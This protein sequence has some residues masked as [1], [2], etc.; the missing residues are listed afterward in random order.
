VSRDV[1]GGRY[2]LLEVLG[3]EGTTEVVRAVDLEH[4]RA[5]ALKVRRLTPDVSREGLLAEGRTLLGARPHPSLPTVRDG[6]FLDDDSYVLVMDWVEGIGLER[7]VEER[8]DPGLP[9]GAVLLGLEAAAAALD[10]LHAHTPPI[11]HGDVQ[12]KNILV[13]PDAHLTLVFGVG[14]TG[15]ALSETQSPYR[16]PEL[17]HSAPTRST[18]VYGL[19]ATA[20]F[21]L[22]GSPPP[23]D[24]PV[25]WVG[26]PPDL[27]KRIDRVI[28]RALDPDPARRPAGAAGFVERL[29]ATRETEVPAG[30]VT[31]VLTDVEGSTDLWEAHPA[32]MAKVM[33][34]HYELA[35][36][37]A[38]A[39]GG[40]MP[41][42]QGEGDSTL[43]AYARATDALDAIL[44]F[45]RAI[46]AEPWPD[47]IDLRVRAG[48][49]TGEAQVEYG[50]Y[51]GATLNRAAR[52]RALARGGEVLLSQ[53]TAE[54]VIDRLPDGVT[55]EDLGRVQL[56][57]LERAEEVYQLC[58]PDLL[59]LGPAPA[60]EAATQVSTRLPLP[61]T[62]RAD[63]SVFVGRLEPMTT[64]RARWERTKV[65]RRRHVVLVSGEPGIGK[66][67][68]A[69]EVARRVYERAG[70]TVLHGRC[71]QESVVPYQPFVEVIEHIVRNGEP[72]Q[73]RS[74]IVRSGTLL[75]R[76]APD[77][78]LRFA[79]LP[80]PVRAEPGTERYLMFE[81][82]NGMLSELAKRAP[83]LVLIDDLHWADSP[84]IA[85]L[86]HLARTPDPA[87][88]LIFGTYRADEVDSEHPLSAALADLRR[89]R[90]VDEVELAGL[91]EA[92]VG[93]LI[94]TC[95][96][97]S[98]PEFVHSV[99]LETAGNPFYIR[100]ICSHVGELGGAGGAFTLETLGIPE[101][102]KQVIGQRIARLPDGAARL[103]TIGAVIG[104]EFDLDVVLEIDGGDED[105]VLDLLDQA[106]EAR[107]VE[108][109]AGRL[110][111]YSFVHALT[112]DALYES[113]GAARR[114]RLHRR[115]AEA[116]ELRRSSHLDDHLAELAFH[117]SAAGTEVPKA[118]EYA[119]RAGEL[120]LARLAHEEAAEHF[121][122]GLVL[123]Q[124][125]DAE[126]CDLLLGLA[127]ARRRAGDVPGSQRAFADAGAVARELG[128]AERLARA[129]VGNFRGHVL[130]NPSWHEPTVALLEEALV[131][132]P[133]EDSSLRSRVLAA[134]SLELY[135]TAA[136]ER[137]ITTGHEAIEMAR[138]LG[139][140]HAL[141]FA[142]ACAHT[143]IS[144][145]SFLSERL[146]L[147]TELI[148]VG[149]RLGN[150]ELALVG[151]VHRACDLL[152]LTR[153]DDARADAAAAAAIVEQLGQPIQRYFV[154]W[155]QSTLALLEGRFD[156]AEHL[157]NEALD[158]AA[159]ADHPDAFVVWGT[160]AVVFAWQRGD[161]T[162]LLEPSHRLLG[163]FPDLA[164]WPAAVALVEAI[165]GHVDD[166]RQRLQDYMANA[167]EVRFGATWI[168]ATMSLAEVA[169]IV[170]ERDAA[171]TLYAWLAPYEDNLCV[172]S[173]NLSELGPVS[174]SLGV[175]ATLQGD[176]ERAEQHF[177]RALATSHAIG[178][179]PHVARISV[180][181]ARM[182]RARGGD[183]DAEC[184]RTLLDA[185]TVT[186]RDL[187][188]VGLL[189]DIESLG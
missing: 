111:R 63:E 46:Q 183:G 61:V 180:D 24:G 91:D 81:A 53:A 5:V 104:R 169:R 67:R 86:N 137:G 101:G 8:G 186:A 112:R 74:D 55:L 151:H 36:D 143:S 27:A 114:A 168:A 136:R 11:I 130:A 7:F 60:L 22:T 65:D 21:A 120:A 128:D 148:A 16:A 156:D 163:D 126:R 78:A 123:L 167:E 162:N 47:G 83:L 117:Y 173:L 132:L 19:A 1:V 93:E 71:Y 188:M 154:L 59:D 50:E 43:T 40:R 26:V 170:D 139:D 155:L 2:E 54:L 35:A 100:E 13:D 189:G 10:H 68:L 58:S 66:S 150:A 124:M 90:L 28:R 77:I 185:A 171:A 69:A 82:V 25:D 159:A 125:Q 76:L 133:D 29:A 142:L 95:D 87:P 184:S 62:L 3:R 34:R 70:A 181:Y 129:A 73:V 158:F 85:L 134:L 175:L 172:V 153:V 179:P 118:V 121:E 52:V 144:D 49:H 17:A 31:F 115:V 18:D 138:R 12:P 98:E 14:S 157:S 141:A 44:A 48:L 84:T 92:D 89:E 96:L 45:Q 149:D 42:S 38:E 164:S 106:S 75:T 9:L 6:F 20:V 152:E 97:A 33:M 122:R 187:R 160:Q 166:A 79:D 182:L 109:V 72:G 119:R 127:E 32:A 147:S 56:K 80:E 4:D 41:R 176:Y 15:S 161:T 174:R 110:G 135:F 103:L 30:V 113:L 140:D 165:A 146:A 102:V 99:L 57:G 94:A 177:E 88:V 51:F 108:E 131:A 116:L 64:L 39:H 178:A 107:L 105:A 23:S 37:V 145:P